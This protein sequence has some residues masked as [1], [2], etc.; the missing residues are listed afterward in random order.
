[1]FREKFENAADSLFRV[2]LSTI[3]VAAG[4]KHFVRPDAIVERLIDAP[5]GGLIAAYVSPLLATYA[6]GVVL[7]TGGVALLLGY[8][9]RRAAFAL[10]VVLIPITIGVHVGAGANP[11]PLLKNIGLFGALLHFIAHG[12]DTTGGDTRIEARR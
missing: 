7:L 10:A 4:L 1:M 3:F 8:Q 9:T 6:T 5:V 11:G 2:L 12:N